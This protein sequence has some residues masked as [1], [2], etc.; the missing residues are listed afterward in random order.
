MEDNKR[1]VG[2]PTL[3]PDERSYPVA[4]R[5]TPAQKVIYKQVGGARWVARMIDRMSKEAAL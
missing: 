2:R 4:L 1:K 5:L 3:P